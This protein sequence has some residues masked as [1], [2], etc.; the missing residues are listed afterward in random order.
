MGDEW[1]DSK[2]GPFCKLDRSPQVCVGDKEAEE[3]EDRDAPLKWD[4]AAFPESVNGGTRLD[5]DAKGATSE[6]K[7]VSKELSGLG[8]ELD[9]TRSAAGQAAAAM[10]EMA[11]KIDRMKSYWSVKCVMMLK[12]STSWDTPTLM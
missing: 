11:D 10:H 7:K 9:D 2:F 1:S 4:C 5:M 12:M 6:A 3:Q 8:D